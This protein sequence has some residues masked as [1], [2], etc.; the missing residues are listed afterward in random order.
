MIDYGIVMRKKIFNF[1]FIVFCLFGFSF[2]SAKSVAMG[3]ISD[4]SS[5][6]PGETLKIDLV[7]SCVAE[8][9][10]V[11]KMV[12]G[13]EYDSGIFSDV[14]IDNVKYYSGWKMDSSNLDDRTGSFIINV[15]DG[16]S[17]NYIT[18]DDASKSCGDSTYVTLISGIELKVR[19]AKN[20]DTK[21]WVLQDNERSD[22]VSV[23]IFKANDNS[24]LKALNIEGVSFSPKFSPDVPNYEASV[25]YDQDKIVI[26]ATCAGDNCTVSNTGEKSLE[27][28]ENRFEIV[29]NAEDGSKKK[30]NLFVN[31][32]KASSD[33]SLASLKIKDSN[34][35]NVSF[36]FKSSK[37]NYDVVVDN[38]ILFVDFTA[39][40]N[41]DN[42][43][44]DNIDTK[45][46]NV[47]DNTVEIKVLAEDGSSSEYKI[48]ITREKKKSIIPYIIGGI[49]L[50]G[51]IAFGIIFFIKRNS[52]KKAKRVNVEPIELPEDNFDINE[53]Q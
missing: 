51:I 44:V 1:L 34:G 7:V 20:Q 33:T 35:K 43:K 50:V 31:R 27:V 30:Y 18:I 10:N 53:L 42:C 28:G 37:H 46:L 49:F 47:G 25:L 8:G 21:I 17:K 5:V 38:D 40:C 3:I 4:K 14:N 45:K 11:K 15:K 13:I 29:V 39:K 48:N 52:D 22:S 26:N 23:S 36:G 41:G 2:V 24:D 9:T 19:D 12:T 32:K 6:K 16:G